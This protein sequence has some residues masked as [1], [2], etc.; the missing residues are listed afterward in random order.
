MIHTS[1][2]RRLCPNSSTS[3][4]ITVIVSKHLPW[5]RTPTA[6]L[7]TSYWRTSHPLLFTNWKEQTRI[8]SSSTRYPASFDHSSTWIR[9]PTALPMP[10]GPLVNR[11]MKWEPLDV[12]GNG[13]RRLHPNHLKALSTGSRCCIDRPCGRFVGFVQKPLVYKIRIVCQEGAIVRKG[14]SE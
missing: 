6:W 7:V 9:S 3:Y 11:Q 5:T 1:S 4:L 14:L 12:S 13:R 8:L 10:S 2:S